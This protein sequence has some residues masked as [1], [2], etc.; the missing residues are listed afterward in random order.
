MNTLRK[1]FLLFLISSQI[2]FAQTFNY[3]NFLSN[4]KTQSTVNATNFPYRVNFSNTETSIFNALPENTKKQ[5]I[6]FAAKIYTTRIRQ[7]Q[8]ATTTI[9]TT[10]PTTN[11]IPISTNPPIRQ[12][13]SSCNKTKFF[14]CTKTTSLFWCFWFKR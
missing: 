7:N 5:I 14:S 12:L 11:N 6:D 8:S 9:A 1:I 3:D 2:S 4:L 10:M 13:V